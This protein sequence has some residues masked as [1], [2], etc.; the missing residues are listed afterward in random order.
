MRRGLREGDKIVVIRN[1]GQIILKSAKDFAKNLEED[2]IF[3][4]R[5]EEA[6]RRYEKGH[7]KGISKEEFIKKIKEW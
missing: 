6:Y 7:F 3:A 5:T 4:K 1:G 2:L